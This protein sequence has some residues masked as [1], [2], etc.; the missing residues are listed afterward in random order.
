MSEE[1][2][3][4]RARGEDLEEPRKALHALEEKI[5]G[6]APV[7]EWMMGDALKEL[8]DRIDRIREV[9]QG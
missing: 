7:V 2:P 1:K 4:R 6:G 9:L 8:H 5:Q 3:E